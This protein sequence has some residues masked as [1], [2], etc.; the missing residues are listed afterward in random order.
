VH[1][2]NVGRVGV[3]PVAIREGR[4]E[5]LGETPLPDHTAAAVHLLKIVV[6][7]R[8]DLGE[9]HDVAVGEP[10]HV[11]VQKVALRGQPVA[12]EEAAIPVVDLD[13]IVD[14]HHQQAALAVE[15]GA[16]R[17]PH[18]RPGVHDV[19]VHVEEDRDPALVEL[20]VVA[21]RRS[22]RRIALDPGFGVENRDVEVH[23][24]AR[25]R[26]VEHRWTARCHRERPE[27]GSG[28]VKGAQHGHLLSLGS[29]LQWR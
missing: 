23:V 3:A 10:D 1:R 8:L 27:Q 21:A 14:A 25:R 20:E 15:P 2:V 7:R 22:L 6:P 12:P 16:R 5:V 9:H 4:V 28:G 19:A 29:V 13:R 11:V 24:V 26:L 17:R 18:Q